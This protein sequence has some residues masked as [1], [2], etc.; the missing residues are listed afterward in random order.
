MIV[1]QALNVLNST[2]LLNLFALLISQ[3]AGS[4]QTLV[5]TIPLTIILSREL[6]LNIGIVELKL[7]YT[8]KRK[9]INI[10]TYI[11]VT[12]SSTQTGVT[13]AMKNPTVYPSLAQTAN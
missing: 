11:F 1:K 7:C 13:I 4:I 3:S 12:A 10:F 8:G 9:D 5:F 6:H 2:N